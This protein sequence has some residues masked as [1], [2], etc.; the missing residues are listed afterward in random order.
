MAA[1]RQA[2]IPLAIRG[3]RQ[4][5][6]LAESGFV[7]PLCAAHAGANFGWHLA[8]RCR[9]AR[10]RDHFNVAAAMTAHAAWLDG[11]ARI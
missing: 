2:M 5:I 9:L 11:K 7:E 1:E 6:Q 8:A 10:N 4:V 3:R